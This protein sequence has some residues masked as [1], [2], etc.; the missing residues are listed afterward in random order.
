MWNFMSRQ[1]MARTY[2]ML[3]QTHTVV[4]LM[5]IVCQAEKKLD[6]LLDFSGLLCV[7][8][9]F[10]FGTVAAAAAVVIVA[11]T[12]TFGISSHAICYLLTKV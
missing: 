9:D 5:F 8:F 12:N 3:R 11:A 6:F 1:T 7:T 10:N 2:T 4:I